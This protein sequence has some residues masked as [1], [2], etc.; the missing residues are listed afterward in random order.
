MQ[1]KVD[2]RK[3]IGTVIGIIVFVSF[4][5]YFTYA[6]YEWRSSNN[7]VNLTIKDSSV[8]CTN[9]PSV[10]VKNIG[11]VLSLKDGVKASFNIK[12]TGNEEINLTLGLNITSI[13]SFLRVASLKWAVIRD[14]TG[15]SD[16]DYTSSP[17]LSGNF[18][19]LSVGSN[20][21]STALKVAANSTYSFQFIVYID[22]NIPNPETMMEGAL[23]ATI[24][25]GECGTINELLVLPASL[26][27]VPV[28]SFVKYTG[29]N[30][31]SYNACKGQNEHYVDENDMG[32]CNISDYKFNASGWRV[33]YVSDGTAYLTSAGS[34]E[35][36]STDSSGNTSHNGSSYET[37]VGTP[38]HIANLN[39]KAL[40][41]CN[42]TYA[43]GGVCDSTS[44]WNMK[45][46]DFQK[47]TGDTIS[48]A[49]LKSNGYYN[50]NSLID[51]GGYYWYAEFYSGSST[52]PCTFVWYASYPAVDAYATGAPYGIR[53]VLRLK[54]SVIATG[55]SGT[56]D[57]PYTIA[58]E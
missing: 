16:F 2:K 18:N 39:S 23:N 42:S 11:P 50:D 38:K 20:T 58:V 44:A 4:A 46:E 36:M 6:W 5:L 45:D 1:E 53:P 49:L 10:E 55:G 28:G 13:S 57:D 35:C 22:G 32:Y 47:I 40:T 29:N 30:G 3:V 12:N 14:I 7:T 52:I 8:E 34:P 24:T 15:E 25:Y 33:A 48:D 51:T 43:Y 21:L 41:Y 54:S 9:G 27:K 19:N 37:T 56:M 31:C 17:V 26:T